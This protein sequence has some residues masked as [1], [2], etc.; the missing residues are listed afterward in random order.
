MT[1]TLASLP[2]A[3]ES[4]KLTRIRVPMKDAALQVWECHFDR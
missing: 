1:G 3:G 2:R 4:G